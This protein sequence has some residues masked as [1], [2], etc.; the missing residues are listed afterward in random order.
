MKFF[1]VDNLPRT[2][3]DYMRDISREDLKLYQAVERSIE[4]VGRPSATG[5]ELFYGVV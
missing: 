2:H 4:H 1:E 5:R 3:R